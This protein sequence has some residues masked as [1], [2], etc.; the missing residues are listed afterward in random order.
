M[1]EAFTVFTLIAVALMVIG[2][3]GSF[4]PMLPGALLS[5]AGILVY[6]WSTN[7]ARP[8]L[9]FLAGFI[10]VGLIAVITDYFAGSIAA[11]MGGAS[12]KTSIIAGVAGFLAFFI[13]GPIGIL[14]GVAATV[15]LREFLISGNAEKSLKAAA[16]STAGVLGSTAVQFLITVSLLLGFVIALLV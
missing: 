9:W 2:V 7:F 13:I 12:T 14:A 16:Y 15:F 1:A 10:F 6:A 8:N 4:T 11:K 5:I 3:I